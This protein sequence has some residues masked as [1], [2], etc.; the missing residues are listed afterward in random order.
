MRQ[1]TASEVLSFSKLLQAETIG[2]EVAKATVG[3]IADEQLK[4]L[5]QSGITAS[6]ARIRGLQQFIAENNVIRVGEVQ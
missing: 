5:T 6:E 4:K 3:V 1:L 2:L